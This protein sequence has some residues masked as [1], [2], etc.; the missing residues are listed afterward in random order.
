MDAPLAS[1]VADDAALQEA[2][3]GD[4]DAI[5]NKALKK[6]G[7]RA[8]RDGRRARPGLAPPPRRARGVG[9]PGHARLPGSI[10][11]CV[12]YRVPVTAVAV[13]VVAF[14]LALGV[15]A[16]ALVIFVLLLGLGAALWQAHRARE[17]ARIARK[18]AKTAAAVQAFVLDIF[19]ANKV[20]QKDPLQAQKTTAR[21]LLDIGTERITEALRDA[22]ESRLEVLVTLS[23]MY[24]ELGLRGDAARLTRDATELARRV[25]GPG[26]ARFARIALNAA[27]KLEETA[28][29]GEIPALLEAADAALVASGQANSA[30][31][32]ELLFRLALHYRYQSLP[33]LLRTAE[34][35][36]RLVARTMADKAPQ[37]VI[38]S[39]RHA[40]R[41]QV[42]AGYLDR[43]EPHYREAVRLAARFDD[44]RD[45]A[46]SLA[47][48]ELSEVVHK[49]GRIDE[50]ETLGRESVEHSTRAHGPGHRWTLIVT[51]RLANMLMRDG[52]VDESLR[53]R[54][55]VTRALAQDRPEYDAQFRADMGGYLARTLCERGRP[56]LAEALLREDL[57]DLRRHF[58]LSASLAARECDMADILSARGQYDEALA[59]ADDATR[60]WERY[61]GG[62]AAP[63]RDDFYT[64]VS[65]RALLAAGRPHDARTRLAGL[66]TSAPA[67]GGPLRS[68]A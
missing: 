39:R 33:S 12:R 55:E 3:Q 32:A 8:L 22:P 26:D 1:A 59:L 36:A 27:E 51:I 19:R 31:R 48:A 60:H 42:E 14:G 30:E 28:E 68:C 5:L 34:E 18:E 40:G 7:G 54:G 45:S 29:R 53:L 52:G 61:A 47:K 17:Q 66:A 58:P 35:A 15:G 2:P 6:Y 10:A 24:Y 21:E 25:F 50:A 23:D 56:D 44:A 46:M 13:A 37:M 16:T 49:L 67:A 65:A 63:A 11:C 38:D 64:L 4:L 9:A 41:A 62:A 20:R 43:A 57:E